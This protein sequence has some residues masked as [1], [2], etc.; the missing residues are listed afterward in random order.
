MDNINKIENQENLYV[1]NLARRAFHN[2][3]NIDNRSILNIQKELAPNSN[4][5]PK[6]GLPGLTIGLAIG[7]AICVAASYIG[8]PLSP[9]ENMFISAQFSIIGALMTYLRS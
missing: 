4:I 1:R 7:V 9:T 6:S 2:A 8:I 3:P 5:L